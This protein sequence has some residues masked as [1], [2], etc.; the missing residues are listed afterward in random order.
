MVASDASGHAGR[1]LVRFWSH[2]CGRSGAR[3]TPL[4]RSL[5]SVRM[6]GMLVEHIPS[7]DRELNPSVTLRSG[8]VLPARVVL[9]LMSDELQLATQWIVRRGALGGRPRE[10]VP[11]LCH[12]VADRRNQVA[13]SFAGADRREPNRVLGLLRRPGD[14]V[15][16]RHPQ[17]RS[18]SSASSSHSVGGLGWLKSPAAMAVAVSRQEVS[19]AMA[20]CACPVANDARASLTRSRAHFA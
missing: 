6:V 13:P 1:Y 9:A 10:E 11:G 19:S 20:R 16:V 2:N 3:D 12:R 15:V 18:T 7:G 8:L 4:L 14:Q 17:G 5:R